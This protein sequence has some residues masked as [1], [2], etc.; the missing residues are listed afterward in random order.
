M[1]NDDLDTTSTASDGTD[2]DTDAGAAAGQDHTPASSSP[3]PAAD[4]AANPAADPAVHSVADPRPGSS[5]E[6]E[7]RWIT[8]PAPTPVIIGIVGLLT[9]VSTAVWSLTDWAVNWAVAVPVGIIGL[10]VVIVGLG[11]AGLRRPRA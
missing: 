3:A 10:G 9:L 8:G 11:V 4:H 2:L 7:P 5:A 1:T 6:A